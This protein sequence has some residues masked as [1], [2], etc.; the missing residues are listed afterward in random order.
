[1]EDRAFKCA[2]T[3]HRESKLAE[4]WSEYSSE[5]RALKQYMLNAIENVY[6]SGI[7]YFICGMAHGCDLYFAET[8]LEFKQEHPDVELEAAIP[9][10]G[11]ADRWNEHLRQ[12]YEAVLR[13]CSKCTVIQQAYTR[14]CM[15]RRNRYMV[16]NAAVLIAVYNGTPGGT[17]NTILYAMR[18]GLEIIEIEVG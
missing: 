3:G 6:Q 12:R 4:N 2:F 14:D 10:A 5:Y 18:Q 11:Q 7:H 13:A 15:M 1:M 9:Y 16:D 8:V 17:R